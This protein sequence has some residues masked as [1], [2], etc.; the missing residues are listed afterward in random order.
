MSTS[1]QTWETATK[2]YELMTLKLKQHS[3]WSIDIYRS[4]YPEYC[5]NYDNSS[6]QIDVKFFPDVQ[7]VDIEFYEI[8][9]RQ[10]HAYSTPEDII[11]IIEEIIL[12]YLE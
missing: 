12:K 4:F 11:I 3:L 6:I 2:F 5:I 7:I 8:S 1:K 10:Y 9:Y